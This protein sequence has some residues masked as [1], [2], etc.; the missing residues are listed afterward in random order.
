MV[1]LKP[2][3]KNITDKILSKKPNWT[4]ADVRYLLNKMKEIG[5]IH[6]TTWKFGDSQELKYLSLL[7][8]NISIES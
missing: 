7:L 6:I 4:K 5:F 1:E 3:K 2:F 8:K